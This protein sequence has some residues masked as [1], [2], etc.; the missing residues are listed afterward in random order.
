MQPV[1]VL[2]LNSSSAKEDTR[3]CKPTH[4][5]IVKLYNSFQSFFGVLFDCEERIS[6]HSSSHVLLWAE[7]LV[8]S[9]P[10]HP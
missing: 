10:P 2:G 1:S 9:M 6:N 4:C 7:P 8:S 5:T 3:T